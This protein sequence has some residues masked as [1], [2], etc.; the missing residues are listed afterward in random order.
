[1]SGLVLKKGREKS[2]RRRHPWVFS[3]AIDKVLGKP[4]P[5]DTV[6]VK[7]SSGKLYGKAAYSAKSQIRARVWTFDPEEEVDGAF[8]RA[9]LGR[10]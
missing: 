5:G 1:M 8:F 2:L 4:G 10:E 7:D 6:W 3:G 9:R